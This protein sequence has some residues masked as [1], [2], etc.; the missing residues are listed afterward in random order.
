MSPRP[1]RISL[2]RMPVED[3]LLEDTVNG[4]SKNYQ[5]STPRQETR[6]NTLIVRKREVLKAASNLSPYGF[7]PACYSQ[8]V[9][10]GC[11]PGCGH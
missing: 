7:S 5:A 2:E 6:V 3:N 11:I 8:E 9:S 1:P 4:S 10:S